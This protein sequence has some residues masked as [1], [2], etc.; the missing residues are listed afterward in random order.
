MSLRVLIV[1][2]EP[3]GRERVRTF[4]EKEDDIE[5]VGESSDGLDAIENIRELEPELVF[6]DVQMPGKNGLE[7]IDEIGP[8]KMPAVIFVTAYDQYALD[9]FDLHAVDYL[10]KPFDR[11]RF[12]RALERARDKLKQQGALDERLLSLLENLKPEGGYLERIVV[13][14][15]GRI[16]F[17]RVADIHWIEAAGNYVRLHTDE[18][19]HLLRE[20]MNRLEKRLDP[21]R[22]LRIHR[23]TIVNLEAV[24]ELQ[25]WFHGEYAVILSDG[26]KLTMSRTYRDRLQ[27]LFG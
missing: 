2:D 17:V 21:D 27:H 20:T 15:S 8:E 5:I 16:V 14:S 6:L 9:A 1:D 25:P 18:R 10:L 26:N 12:H 19:V 3:L 4:L 22:F 24:K 13:K 11:D 23:S 7:V